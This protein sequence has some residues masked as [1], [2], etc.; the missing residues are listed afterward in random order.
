MKWNSTSVHVYREKHRG[1]RSRHC[2]QCF[3]YPL[4][5]LGMYNSGRGETGGGPTALLSQCFTKLHTLNE[6]KIRKFTALQFWGIKVQI[7]G[8]AVR[9]RLVLCLWFPTVSVCPTVSQAPWPVF[10]AI[11]D[12]Q[13]FL[14][15]HPY[16]VRQPPSLQVI[17][18]RWIY[19]C[20][21]RLLYQWTHSDL[22]ISG[23]KNCSKMCHYEGLNVSFE[24]TQLTLTTESQRNDGVWLSKSLF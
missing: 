20:L 24:D 18:P 13:T 6:F 1:Y 23:E 7:K 19:L 17:V 8:V 11:S 3:G 14:C 2:P 15:L 12:Q 16:L 21:P 5:N 4:D 22:I 9:G 10:L